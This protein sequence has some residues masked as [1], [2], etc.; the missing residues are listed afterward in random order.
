[1]QMKQ[2]KLNKPSQCCPKDF[3]WDYIDRCGVS[4]EEEVFLSQQ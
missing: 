4:N 2:K 3:N 1:M